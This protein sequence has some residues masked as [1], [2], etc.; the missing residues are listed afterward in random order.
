MTFQEMEM[1]HIAGLQ[2]MPSCVQVICCEIPG[3]FLP[4][5]SITTHTCLVTVVSGPISLQALCSFISGLILHLLL[6]LFS[7]S[8]I[9]LDAAYRVLHIKHI[10]SHV[11]L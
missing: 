3:L 8:L 11:W 1:Q 5:S 2:L 6:H 9:N 4:G 7:S 10:T